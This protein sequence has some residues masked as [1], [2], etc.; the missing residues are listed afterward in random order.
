MRISDTHCYQCSLIRFTEYF[1]VNNPILHFE[2]LKVYKR[3][4][5]LQK[6]LETLTD[7]V[8]RHDVLDNV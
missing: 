1:H 3:E 7:E 6:I 2:H 5:M 4:I 8:Y